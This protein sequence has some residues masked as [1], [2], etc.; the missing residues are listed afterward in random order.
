MIKETP[1]GGLTMTD[2]E[3]DKIALRKYLVELRVELCV[4]LIKECKKLV[5]ISIAIGIA[6]VLLLLILILQ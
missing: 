3:A 5:Y 4:I 2:P 1:D 6:A